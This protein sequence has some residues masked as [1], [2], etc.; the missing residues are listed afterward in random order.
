MGEST[1]DV[2]NNMVRGQWFHIQKSCRLQE[3]SSGAGKVYP[4]DGDGIGSKL[5]ED[6]VILFPK[7]DVIGG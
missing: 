2:G 5:V 3:L 4:C 7:N 6:V 1:S